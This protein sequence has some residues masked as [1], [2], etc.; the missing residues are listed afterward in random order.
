MPDQSPYPGMP[1]WVK[2]SGIVVAVL[3]VMA[4]IVIAFDIG[5]P[6]GPGRHMSPVRE[7]PPTN[8]RP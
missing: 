7:T 5:G 1:R 3:I 4:A 8:D 6:H 2:I